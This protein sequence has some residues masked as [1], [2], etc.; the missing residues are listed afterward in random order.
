[1]RPVNTLR[2]LCAVTIALGLAA[3]FVAAK[4]QPELGRVAA[5][6]AGCDFVASRAANRSSL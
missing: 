4:A 2:L 1:M 3:P 5:Q 6:A